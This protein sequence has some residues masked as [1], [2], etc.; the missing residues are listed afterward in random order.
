[1]GKSL[2]LRTTLRHA[3]WASLVVTGCGGST[4]TPD[5]SVPAD[6]GG[7]IAVDRPDATTLTDAPDAAV[8]TDRPD[9]P[10]RTDIPDVNVATPDVPDA[11]PVG[12]CIP[13]GA[14][15]FAARVR[16]AAMAFRD[17]GVGSV[18]LTEALDLYLPMG[19]AAG[20]PVV[21]AFE[22]GWPQRRLVTLQG[23][24]DASLSAGGVTFVGVYTS[25]VSFGLR[26]DGPSGGVVMNIT[27]NLSITTDVSDYVSA[28][29]TLCPA[30]D[31]PAATLAYVAD[32]APS[33][34]LR[35]LPSS[36]IAAGVDGVRM[37]A[38]GA[39]VPAT[40]TADDGV[41]VVTPTAPW[42]VNAEV[43][44]DLSSLRDV[45]G[46][47]YTTSNALTTL[48]TTAEL[49]DATFDT[50][51]P[52]GA[53]ASSTANV[54]AG[55]LSFAMARARQRALVSLG[56]LAGAT[57]VALRYR[58]PCAFVSPPTARLLAADGRS[59]SFTL[60]PP[61]GAPSTLESV[62]DVPGS[63]PLWL[64]LEQNDPPNRPGWLPA[65]ACPLSIESVGPAST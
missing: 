20:A 31:A 12:E 64:L 47:P 60:A 32:A 18:T 36:P 21:F 3:F 6:L 11:G 63:G 5:A 14:S 29:V 40:V 7:D 26:L 13:A 45:M 53:V 24:F 61:M 59:S 56:A 55:S 39:A 51:P 43:A 33:L 19:R 27:R 48:R 54:A 9:V 22:S 4:V 37:T 23:A 44:L 10:V 8:T 30:G 42:P 62:V 50:A 25:D 38:G 35:L 57:R 16:G 46:R 58:Y 28:R 65:P 49:T 52:A 2:R 15:P 41:L 17:A 34:D 1:M